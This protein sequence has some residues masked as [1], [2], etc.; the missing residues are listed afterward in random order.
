MALDS[1]PTTS[2]PR[3][4]FCDVCSGIPLDQLLS[5]QDRSPSSV[6]YLIGT[7]TEVESRQY[8]SLYRAYKEA[9]GD[10]EGIWGLEKSVKELCLF[11]IKLKS[12]DRSFGKYHLQP[13]LEW[14]PLISGEKGFIGPHAYL[15]ISLRK[16]DHYQPHPNRYTLII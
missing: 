9:V 2:T 13:D 11:H 3:Q 7:L 5:P 4:V 1:H 8:C 15:E 10:I 16:P 6:S 14:F 12:M